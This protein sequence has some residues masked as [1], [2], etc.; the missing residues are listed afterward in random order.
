[1]A[2]RDR[3]RQWL[4]IE[5]ARTRAAMPVRLPSG[6]K[7]VTTDQENQIAS[8]GLRLLSKLTSEEFWRDM[9]LD[10]RTLDRVPAWKLMELLIELSPE[11]SRARWDFLRMCNPGWEC[12][13]TR[14]GSEAEDA[15][16]RALALAEERERQA[17]NGGN[18]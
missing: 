10:S 13:V 16:A 9:T 6:G 18:D 8:S 12:A 15:Q 17:G 5:P 2:F 14:P 11:I 4:G 3:I 1:M 7:R